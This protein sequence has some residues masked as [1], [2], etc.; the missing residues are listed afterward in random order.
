MEGL[1]EALWGNLGVCGVCIG[2]KV[3]LDGLGCGLGLMTLCVLLVK[4]S[5]TILE[6]RCNI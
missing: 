4:L 5:P 3:D 1:W 6:K 2:L